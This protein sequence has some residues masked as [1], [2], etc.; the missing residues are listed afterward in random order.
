MAFHPG[1]RPAAP[2]RLTP[3][4]ALRAPR[5]IAL[6][7]L[8][9]PALSGCGP[10]RDPAPS[11]EY[12]AMGS[13][14]AAGPG[15]GSR[16]EGSP[17]LCARSSANYAHLVAAALR[18]TLRDV[19]CSGATIDNIL[20]KRQAHRAPQINAI[21]PKTRLVTITVGGNDVS[22]LGNLAGES[23]ANAKSR[24]PWFW[25]PVVCS[26]T[27]QDKVEAAFKALPGHLTAMVEAVHRLA[28][29][30]R[31][32]LVDYVTVL[33]TSGT[34]VDRAPLSAT[35]IAAGNAVAQRLADATAAAARLSG[36]TLVKASAVTKGHDVCAT[37]PWLFG[38]VF[39]ASPFS[40]GPFSYH[41]NAQA[42]RAVADAVLAA[43]KGGPPAASGGA[44]R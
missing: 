30:A 27:P 34:C 43:L 31:V 11:A 2:R 39:P 1:P 3:S 37:D 13:S 23:C 16:A 7:G 44:T 41:P 20:V 25:R 42:M 38:F 33:P 5:A 28:P 10:S 19:T 8:V 12:V 15:V 9:A 29:D 17:F 32:V 18:L 40:W 6:L 22:Y 26:V 24:V 35:Q 14:Y 21:G 36:A 4:R